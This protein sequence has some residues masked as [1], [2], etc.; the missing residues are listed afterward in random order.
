VRSNNHL[1][2]RSRKIRPYPVRGP[3]D[4]E[5]LT[6]SYPANENRR[7]IDR[8]QGIACSSFMGERDYA[9]LLDSSQEEGTSV[10]ELPSIS[11]RFPIIT[12]LRP[13]PSVIQWA[14][15]DA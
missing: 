13:R 14:G 12:Q 3:Q 15:K 11:P 2:P 1:I 10:S 9:E 5:G 8:I 6:S 4:P 7:G